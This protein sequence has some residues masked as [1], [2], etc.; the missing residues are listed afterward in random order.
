M[1][2]LKNNEV[3][4]IISFWLDK[5]S[6]LILQYALILGVLF[7]S[8]LIAPRVAMGNRTTTLLLVLFF[9]TILLTIVLRWPTLGLILVIVG[10]MF[11]PF[12]WQGGFN[13]SQLGLAAM[14]GVWILDMLVIQRKFQIVKSRTM[15]PIFIFGLISIISFCLGQYSWY[16]FAR[17]APATS[18]LGGLMINLLS[19]GAFLLVAHLVNDVKKLEYL[20][21]TFIVF[22]SIYVMGRFLKVGMIDRFFQNGFSAGS[23]FWTWLVAMLAG[24]VMGNR[25]LNLRIRS[26]LS[27]ILLITFYVAL[28]QAYDWRSGWFPPL[29]AFAGILT[30]RYWRRVKYFAIL[31]VIPLYFIVTSSIGQEDWSWGTRLDAWKIV[32]NIASVSPILGMGFANYY[33]YTPLF[34]IRGYFVRFNSHSQFVDLI[35]QTGI[36]GLACFLWFFTEVGFLGMRLLKRSPEGFAK[37][38][39]YG[40]L[41]GLIGTLVAAYLVDWVLPFVYNIGM[42][43]FRASILAWLFL[44][45]I[46]SIEQI[47]RRQANSDDYSYINQEG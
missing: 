26:I 21:W 16:P 11:V 29:I 38:Y 42:N 33:W 24:Q 2:F 20:T 40:A 10:G 46:V 36:L 18:Q 17:N 7:A 19:I 28:V 47:V 32:L 14:L 1:L 39:L 30:I 12:S 27:I 13:V 31:A 4:K 45:G 3:I 44:G 25:S 41:G 34:P 23:L 35:A 37:G 5:N 43:G 15:V 8:L 9:A 22:G 6:K